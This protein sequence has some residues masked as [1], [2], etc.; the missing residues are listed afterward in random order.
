ME[1]GHYTEKEK[2]EYNQNIR[3]L[4][5]ALRDEEPFTFKGFVSDLCDEAKNIG[6]TWA[7][8]I[9]TVAVL[10]AGI[11]P[12]RNYESNVFF[13][14]LLPTFKET[15]RAEHTMR[16]N[17]SKQNKKIFK[18]KEEQLERLLSENYV[19]KE[20]LPIILEKKGYFYASVPCG[21]N[22]KEECSYLR[23][24]SKKIPI[25][26]NHKIVEYALQVDEKDELNLYPEKYFPKTITR[27]EVI[28]RIKETD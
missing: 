10:G 22:L 4:A 3:N 12:Y 20:R 28:Y 23:K 11:I 8:F 7:Y 17:P 5:N 27:N 19:N 16:S 25:K 13:D 2:E 26:Q 14:N 6:K 18:Q 9:G 21:K 15:I 24:I 1:N